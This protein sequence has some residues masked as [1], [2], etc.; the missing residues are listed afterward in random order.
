MKETEIESLK[1]NYKYLEEV[2]SYSQLEDADYVRPFVIRNYFK[3]AKAFAKWDFDFFIE[4]YGDTQHTISRTYDRLNPKTVNLKEYIEN[5]IKTSP[6]K[7]PYYLRSWQFMENAPELLDDLDTPKPVNWF[8]SLPESLMP[9]KEYRLLFIGSKGTTFRLHYDTMMVSSWSAVF[10]GKKLWIFFPHD[11]KT[12]LNN[13]NTDAFNPGDNDEL[14]NLKPFFIVQNKGDLL[15]TPSG[16]WHQVLNIE[17]TISYTEN[18]LNGHNIDEIINYFD[19]DDVVTYSNFTHENSKL[20]K[21][22]LLNVKYLMSKD[23]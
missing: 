2:K 4:K 13:G 18:V 5:Y 12:V 8:E 15:F 17:P 20:W 22:I 6:S 21:D 9:E 10:E 19:L 23:E 16:W 14:R 3:G 1:A 11:N 7:D